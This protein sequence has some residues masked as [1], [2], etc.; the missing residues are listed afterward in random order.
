M[1]TQFVED[2]ENLKGNKLSFLNGMAT[3]HGP[4]SVIA[5]T[6]FFERKWNWKLSQRID[7]TEELKNQ[8][9][10]RTLLQSS[11]FGC[12]CNVHLKKQSI[13][14]IRG[15]FTT[16]STQWQQQ[17]CSSSCISVEPELDKKWRIQSQKISLYT[18]EHWLNTNNLAT[19]RTR[20]WNLITLLWKENPR[21]FLGR[22]FAVQFTFFWSEDQLTLLTDSF[23][24]LHSLRALVTKFFFPKRSQLESTLLEILWKNIFNS[25]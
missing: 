25:C 23:C 6:G 22:H 15:M 1:L 13:F 24:M 4:V 17:Q 18:T 10:K 8:Q 3:G 16:M 12:C 2:W 20:N 5:V 14:T 11:H 7:C 9:G 19:P 21:S